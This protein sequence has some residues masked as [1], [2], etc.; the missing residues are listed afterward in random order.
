M[1]FVYILRSGNEDLFKIGKTQRKALDRV[2]EL[3]TGNPH[4][5]TLFDSI[6]TADAQ[7]AATCEAYL[8]GNLSTKRWTGGEAREFFALT[9]AEAEKAIQ[10][11]REFV[12]TRPPKAE[13]R[14]S[15]LPREK[16]MTAS[17]SQ[18]RRTGIPHRMLVR[19]REEEY[20]LGVD[21]LRLET[22]LKLIIGTAA[23]LDGIATWKNHG[24]TRFDE[25]SFKDAEPDMYKMFLKRS[26]VRRFRLL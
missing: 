3:S 19:V 8:H 15:N 1:A 21:R 5:L 6:K 13:G 17:C 26:R 23:C 10:D 12:V 11:A 2:K 18:V 9:P 25:E 7:D 16:T 20:R 22:D 4:R 14:P 24:V